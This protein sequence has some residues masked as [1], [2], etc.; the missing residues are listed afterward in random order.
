MAVPMG[1]SSQSLARV[2]DLADLPDSP[3]SRSG[4]RG[5][6]GTFGEAVFDFGEWMKR[7]MILLSIPLQ[8]IDRLRELLGVILLS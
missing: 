4:V 6:R 7:T 8:S 2:G 1:R 5:V 3:L